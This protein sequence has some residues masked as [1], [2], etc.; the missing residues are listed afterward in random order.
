MQTIQHEFVEEIPAEKQRGIL[1][2]SLEFAVAS[3][4]CPCGCGSLVVT[5]IAPNGWSLCFN[6][7]T[8]SLNPSIGNWSLPCQSHYWI[9]DDRIRWARKF[10]KEEINSVRLKD[11]RD[12]ETGNKNKRK[13]KKRK[14][15]KSDN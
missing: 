4:F 10:G 8:V 5:R 12:H 3:H 1:Y 11:E 9:K 15:G 7:E 6:G 13:R 14:D 2:I